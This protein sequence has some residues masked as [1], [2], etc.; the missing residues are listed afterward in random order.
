MRCK[1]EV[2]EINFPEIFPKNKIYLLEQKM[3]KKSL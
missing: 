3:N 2:Y 1:S